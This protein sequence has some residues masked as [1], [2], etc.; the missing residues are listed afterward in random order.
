MDKDER[1]RW[2]V[3]LEE[4]D[5]MVQEAEGERLRRQAELHRVVFEAERAGMAQTEIG[6]AL[7]I[8]RQRVNQIVLAAQQRKEEED[9]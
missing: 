4:A 7:G 2:V 5:A 9:T 6:G 3:R 1:L 8:S